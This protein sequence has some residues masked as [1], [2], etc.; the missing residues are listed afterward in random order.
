MLG[1]T[2]HWGNASQNTMKSYFTVIRVAIIHK[3]KKE[4][5]TRVGKDV[6]KLESSCF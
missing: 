3:K 4:K 5:I 2:N 1:I 6:E